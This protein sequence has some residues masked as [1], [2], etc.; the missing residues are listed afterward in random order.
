MS[1]FR[2]TFF[3]QRQ[4]G[5]RPVLSHKAFIFMFYV[6]AAA[7]ICFGLLLYFM[8]KNAPEYELRYDQTCASGTCT[9]KL[10]IDRD[11]SG[12]VKLQ[13]KL[14]RFHQNHRRF[15][16]SRVYNQLIGE[17]VD[18]DGL[19]NAKP[20][21]SAHDSP[22]PKNWI[23]PSGA[24]AFFAFNDTLKWVN[25]SQRFDEG[26]I[27]YAEESEFLFAPLNEKYTTGNKWIENNEAFPQGMTDPHFIQWMRQTSAPTVYKDWGVCGDC[28][29][30]KGEYE[31]EIVSRY[32]TDLFGGGKYIVLTQ[33]TAAGDKSYK[34]AVAYLV[35]GCIF[36]VFAT[37]M[38]VAELACSRGFGFDARVVP[39]T[40]EQYKC[41]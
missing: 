4:K 39:V 6:G 23:L 15:I 27:I 21:R 31:I 10:N 12:Q 41:L 34:L 17:Y 2:R 26:A 36:G 30:P 14:T 35:L 13:Y 5:W 16:F 38:T 19:E 9:V 28:S 18:F 24:F 33:M 8:D 3:Q 32:P 29:I 22:D 25:K 1:N 37:L 11:M 20:F 7:S 40:K